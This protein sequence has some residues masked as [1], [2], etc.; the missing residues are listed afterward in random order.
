MSLGPSWLFAPQFSL[1]CSRGA[2]G[3]PA[4]AQPRNEPGSSDMGPS[5]DMVI[6]LWNGGPC[7]SLRVEFQAGNHPGISHIIKALQKAR[8]VSITSFQHFM[9][10]KKKAEVPILWP[11]DIKS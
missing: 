1:C 2:Q 11:P 10:F 6:Y 9:G 5:Q 8:L 7:E 4:G 3:S